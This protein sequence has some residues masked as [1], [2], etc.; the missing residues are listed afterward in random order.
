MSRLRL[1]SF[2]TQRSWL[3]SLSF[4][5]LWSFHCYSA[6]QFH[7]KMIHPIFTPGSTYPSCRKSIPSL[8]CSICFGQLF[9]PSMSRS[10]RQAQCCY[11]VAGKNEC[12]RKCPRTRLAVWAGLLLEV[13]LR[14]FWHALS[15][16]LGWVWWRRGWELWPRS[17]NFS[18]SRCES[19]CLR[20]LSRI[21]HWLL[22]ASGSSWCNFSYITKLRSL[23]SSKNCSSFEPAPTRVSRQSAKKYSCWGRC[24]RL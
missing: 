15:C 11:G 2:F 20:G 1:I 19:L 13:S 9:D 10:D 3:A 18:S 4:V 23:Q 12:R 17:C 6:T 8:S 16:G 14:L 7:F 21:S 24:C 5:V 22:P